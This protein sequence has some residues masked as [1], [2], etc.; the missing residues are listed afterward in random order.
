MGVYINHKTGV[1]FYC[2]QWVRDG[3]AFER[4]TDQPENS[5]A[6]EEKS[7]PTSTERQQQPQQQREESESPAIEEAALKVC[8]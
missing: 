7:T 5:C 2:S 3:L 1:V 4:L 8:N 6:A